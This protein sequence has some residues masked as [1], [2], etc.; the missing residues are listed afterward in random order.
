MHNKNN[1]S[2][3]KHLPWNHHGPQSETSTP[4]HV[5]IHLEHPPLRCHPWWSLVRRTRSRLADLYFCRRPGGQ[6]AGKRSLLG[7]GMQVHS[8]CCFAKRVSAIIHRRLM[9]MRVCGVVLLLSATAKGLVAKA[10]SELPSER[11]LLPPLGAPA[12]LGLTRSGLSCRGGSSTARRAGATGWLAQQ[13]AGKGG[14]PAVAD[15]DKPWGAKQGWGQLGRSPQASTRTSSS[16]KLLTPRG[17]CARSR[18]CWVLSVCP[19]GHGH[20]ALVAYGHPHASS[21]DHPARATHPCRLLGS[22]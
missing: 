10:G 13:S 9:M 14:L 3:F 4:V 22:S 11:L 20:W 19:A 7:G 17:A 18:V 15:T 1:G 21:G 16:T 6:V 12:D 2:L 8:S 5:E